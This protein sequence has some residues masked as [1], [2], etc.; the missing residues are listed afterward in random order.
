M[1]LLAAYQTLL[2]RHSGQEDFTV[3]SPIAN[4][5]RSEIE[6]LIGFFVNTL[7]MR[8]DLS[9]NPT[10][11]ELLQRVRE[12]ALGA[13]S[14]QDLP[15]EKLVEALQPERDLSRMPLFQVLLCCRTRRELRSSSPG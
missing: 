13:Y 1:I 2:F 6:D 8:G 15:F 4:R 7:V 11:R 10:F 5:I 14:N 9:G 3:G 12:V